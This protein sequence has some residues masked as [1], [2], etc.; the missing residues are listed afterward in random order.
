MVLLDR[1]PLALQCALA[2][3][4]A[5]ALPGVE[6]LQACPGSSRG[7]TWADRFTGGEDLKKWVWSTCVAY[8]APYNLT[9]YGLY[10]TPFSP[11]GL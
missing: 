5:S 10:P 7:S 1:E 9:L 11:Y 2:S 6:V 3:A 4:A 8:S